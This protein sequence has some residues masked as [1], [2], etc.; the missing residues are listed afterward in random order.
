MDSS[1]WKQEPENEWQEFLLNRCRVESSLRTKRQ[2]Q[3][4]D[5]VFEKWLESKSVEEV[6]KLLDVFNKDKKN[7]IKS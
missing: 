6:F 2:I 5:S 3:Y 4:G 1:Y 7:G